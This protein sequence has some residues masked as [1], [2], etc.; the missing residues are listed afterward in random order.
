MF[1][2]IK[3]LLTKLANWHEKDIPNARLKNDQNGRKWLLKTLDYQKTLKLEDLRKCTDRK[4]LNKEYIKRYREPS[5]KAKKGVS[6]IKQEISALYGFNKCLVQRHKGRMHFYRDDLSQK[7]ART[8]A[9][10]GYAHVLFE[11]FKTNLA[12]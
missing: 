2:T 4:E 1:T 10:V 6:A 3:E 8:L 11:A 12:S 5:V 9:S 7:G